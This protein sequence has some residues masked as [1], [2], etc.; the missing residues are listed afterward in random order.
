METGRE[1]DSTDIDTGIDKPR[2]VFGLVLE[3]AISSFAGAP[4]SHYS[5]SRVRSFTVPAHDTP[6]G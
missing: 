2:P 1:G 4:K 3:I 6:R 5:G